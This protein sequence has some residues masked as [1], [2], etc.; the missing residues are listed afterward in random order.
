[1]N[2]YFPRATR[3]GLALDWVKF[4]AELARDGSVDPVDKALYAAIGSFVDAETRE[5]PSMDDLDP[6]HV[7]P[8]VPTRKRLA[9]CIGKSVDTVDRATKR[10][11]SRGLLKVHRQPDPT[12]PRRMLP[13]EYELLDHHVWDERAAQRAADRAAGRANPRSEGGRTGAATPTP[14]RTPAATPG[15]TP[16]ATPGRTD[17]AVKDL[18]EGVEEVDQEQAPSARS[19]GDARRASTGS[20][21]RGARGGSAAT[22]KPAPSR[23]KSRLASDEARVVAVVER[24]VPVSLLELLAGGAVP[25]TWRVS[26][27]RELERGGR[28]P[29][30]LADRVARRWVRHRYQSHL[31]AGRGLDNPY[32][33]LQA[34]VGPG[35]CPDAGCEDGE[36]VDTGADCRTCQE[37]RANRRGA[38]GGVPTQRTGRNAWWE[39]RTCRNPKLERR[40]PEP[41]DRVCQDCNHEVELAFEAL[42]AR[43]NAP[44]TEDVNNR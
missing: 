44:T 13:S 19:A 11:E 42:A 32:K 3:R 28:T 40:E 12:N 14:D 18:Q 15:C 4:D 39:C 20:G 6:N 37:R 26:V 25:Q 2:A 35:E 1:M 21:A 27:L 31:L 8:W 7:P 23:K 38:G 36:M 16:A 43:L 29:E 24:A 17:A 34:L 41:E 22:E 10:L 5:S 33:V 30:Q 9:E